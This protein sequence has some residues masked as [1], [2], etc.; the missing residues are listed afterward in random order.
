MNDRCGFPQR[1]RDARTECPRGGRGVPMPLARRALVEVALALACCSVTAML[2]QVPPT[3]AVVFEN[4]RIFN[5]TD[6]RLSGPSYVLVVENVIKT[7]SST[8]IARSGWR[9]C[10]THSSP[11]ANADAG[12]DRQPLAHHVRS[13]DSRRKASKAAAYSAGYEMPHFGTSSTTTRHTQFFT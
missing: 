5:G 13:P 3:A 1:L 4:V 12:A 7:I 9:H 8:P 11:G 6:A 2:A 10:A